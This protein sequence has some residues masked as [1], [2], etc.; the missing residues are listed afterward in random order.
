VSVL[1]RLLHLSAATLHRPTCCPM[2]GQEPLPP[3]PALMRWVSVTTPCGVLSACS[4]RVLRLPRY[5]WCR[6]PLRGHQTDFTCPGG[7]H[8]PVLP[9]HFGISGVDRVPRARPSRAH[10]LRRRGDRRPGRDVEQHILSRFRS[11]HFILSR[12]CRLALRRPT[13]ESG[14]RVGVVRHSRMKFSACGGCCDFAGPGGLTGRPRAGM[15][16]AFPRFT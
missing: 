13:R 7:C 10:R 8:P 15:L 14:S 2:A 5:R 12:A 3:S 11:C 9:A 1:L 6:R 16:W 4:T